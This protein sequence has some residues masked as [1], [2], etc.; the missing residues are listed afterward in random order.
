M[1]ERCNR[2]GSLGRS[3]RAALSA[4]RTF[5]AERT[6]NEYSSKARVRLLVRA[7]GED[8]VRVNLEGWVGGAEPLA[9]L[10]VSV[11]TYVCPACQAT[12]PD[13]HMI[14]RPR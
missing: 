9:M 7:G 2:T 4:Q 10:E 5:G 6:L 14:S 1:H 3:L 12:C 13:L 8:A 11:L